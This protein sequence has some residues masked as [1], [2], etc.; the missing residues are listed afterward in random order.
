MSPIGSRIWMGLLFALAGMMSVPLGATAQTGDEGPDRK[1]PLLGEHRFITN[2]A[3]RDPFSRTQISQTLGIGRALDVE[4]LPAF[5]VGGDTIDAISGD[6][7]FAVLNFEY[8]HAVKDW[9]GVYVSVDMV[10]RLGTDVGA[11]LSSGATVLSGFELGWLIKL[12]ESDKV[13]LSATANLWN[14]SFTGINLLDWVDG[15][16]EDEPVDLVRSVPS[17]RGGGGLRFAWAASDLVGVLATTELGLGESVARRGEDQVSFKLG[18]AVDFD[19]YARTS[20]PIGFAV[21]FDLTNSPREG[22]DLTDTRTGGFLR[23]AYTG[24]DDFLLALDT[25]LSRLS[26]VEDATEDDV[27]TGSIVLNMRYY[28]RTRRDRGAGSG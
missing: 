17:V 21:G 28:F 20:V 22:S 15:I 26:T 11:L 24:R 23:L 7:L 10:G 19:L 8:Q 16:I 12:V 6:L 2:E 27:S 3:T 4:F 1:R 13:A 5:E 25:G 18:G 14:N 9:L